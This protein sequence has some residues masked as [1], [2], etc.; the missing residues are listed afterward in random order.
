[1]LTQIEEASPGTK[2]QMYFGFLK[3]AAHRFKE[4]D[5]ELKVVA[6]ARC[7]APT[8]EAAEGDPVCSFCK[9]KALAAKRRA[10]PARPPRTR[11]QA[12]KRSG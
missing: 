10:E 12:K 9:L 5:D 8:L 2:Q 4:T 1:A 7:G 11:R 6:C 3:K